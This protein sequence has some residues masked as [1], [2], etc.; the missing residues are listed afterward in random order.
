MA[1]PFALANQAATG[2]SDAFSYD[3]YRPSYPA[4]A[5]EKLLTNLGVANEK[6]ASIVDL[7]CGTGKFTELL[8]ARSEQYQ[9][10]GIEPHSGMRETLERKNLGLSVKIL[11]GD[12]DNMPLKEG[13]G[14]SVIAAQVRSLEIEENKV[15]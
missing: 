5:V 11:D 6:N 3:Q 8:A 2:F 4:Q 13:W 14:D 1:T 9:I 12:A 7:G 15:S 10:V